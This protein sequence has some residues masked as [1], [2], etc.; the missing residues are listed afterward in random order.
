MR[1]LSSALLLILVP[2]HSALF[3]QEIPATTTTYRHILVSVTVG[4]EYI[5][6][7]HVPTS[8]ATSSQSYPVLYVL[9]GDKS[10][11]MAKDVVD[12]LSWS[13]EIPELVVVAISYGGA[14]DVWWQKRSR[15]YT[16]S[17][18][19][20]RVWGDWPLAGGGEAFKQF[21]MTE[22][23]PLVDERYR[24]QITDRAVAGTSFGGLFAMYSLFTTPSLFQ[25]YIAV[26]PTLIWDDEHMWEYEQSYSESHGFLAAN[27]FTA[28]GRLDE[29]EVV[30][31]WERFNALVLG[32]EYEGL[33]WISHTFDG[34]THISV[35]PG[36]FSRGLRSVYGN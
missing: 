34:E 28:V 32:R 19:R 27:V 2:C 31:P 6:D 8:Y 23:F 18:D 17:I 16:P 13:G 14:R 29:S 21:L 5:V 25:R 35:W 33:N 36:A 20:G 11:G 9:D 15:D 4:D 22:L 1:Y 30:D 12:W 7:V 26:G 24:T 3:A 10:S